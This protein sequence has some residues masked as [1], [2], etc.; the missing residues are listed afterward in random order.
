MKKLQPV[1]TAAKV[2]VCIVT[3]FLLA[4][5]STNLALTQTQHW[6]TQARE[7]SQKLASAALNQL[8]W[9]KADE[10]IPL[11]TEGTRADPTDPLPFMLLGMA[12][13]MKG[14]YQEA[15]DALKQAYSLDSKARE[16]YLTVGFS[17]YLSRR[18]EQ[19]INV[20]VKVLQANPDVVQIYT[21]IGY[22][23][24][25]DGKMEDAETNLRE[26]AK[27][28][29]YSQPAYRGLMLLH[30]LNGNFPIARS[31]G[32]Q[33][34]SASGRQVPLMLAEMEFLQGNAQA[35]SKQLSAVPKLR[36]SK[37]SKPTFDM[38][39]LGYLPQHDFHFDPFSK[40][41][42]DNESLIEARFVDLP[43]RESR[44]VQ[45]AR[46]GKADA[47]LSELTNLLS[48][49]PNDP[50][51][52]FQSG[53]IH[54]ANGQFATASEDFVK[55]IGR[56]PE[57]HSAKLYLALSRFREGNIEKAKYALEGYEK[58]CP[59]RQLAPIFTMI[60]NANAPQGQTA[61]GDK[62]DDVF[63]LPPGTTPIDKGGD[64]G[65]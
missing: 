65:F 21:N 52:R 56:V 15:L 30:Y 54:L 8:V 23:Y 50:Y 20:W 58:A 32:Q 14:R 18:F 40:D 57:W 16:T 42:F 61:G 59:G 10:A 49:T 35:A 2:K 3:S 26:C 4:I 1:S 44:R 6:K 41:Y 55:V 11:L 9:S 7:K 33:A 38:V 48:T 51:L 39:S 13:N 53:T 12:L 45:L 25:R 28:S 62:K 24:L 64:T 60:K 29:S 31:A 17:H 27:R 43:K 19:A 22:G 5:S 37:K 46:K 47:A 34:G 63:T 36:T